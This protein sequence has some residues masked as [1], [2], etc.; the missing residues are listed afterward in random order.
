MFFEKTVPSLVRSSRNPL[1]IAVCLFVLLVMLVTL[2]ACSGAGGAEKAV[3]KFTNAAMDGN[4][5]ARSNTP[6]PAMAM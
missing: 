4:F 6:R 3:K 1:V 5:Q 2:S